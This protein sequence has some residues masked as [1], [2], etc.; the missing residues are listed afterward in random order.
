MPLLLDLN[1][2]AD[3]LR[4]APLTWVQPVDLLL[5]PQCSNKMLLLQV[6]LGLLHLLATAPTPVRPPDFA[7]DFATAAEATHSYAHSRHY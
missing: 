5:S 1:L 2:P 6:A 4:S 7:T 3:D